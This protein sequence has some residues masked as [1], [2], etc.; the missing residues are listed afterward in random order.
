M[1]K[2][3]NAERGWI[4]LGL[5]SGSQVKMTHESAILC[6]S[7]IGL[8]AI[9]D[10]VDANG[11]AAGEREADAPVSDAKAVLGRIDT[12]ELLDIAGVGENQTLDRS[13]HTQASSAVQATK[14]NLGLVRENKFLQEGSL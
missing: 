14:V 3:R 10:T 2:E 8:F 4:P 12:L 9:P 6:G 5:K 7:A 13:G 1:G 11:V